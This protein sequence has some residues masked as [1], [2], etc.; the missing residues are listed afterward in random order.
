MILKPET[1]KSDKGLTLVELLV[2]IA[3]ISLIA[4]VSVHLFAGALDSW[5]RNRGKDE[6]LHTAMLTMERM[7]SKVRNTSWVLLPLKVSNPADP[8]YP[9]SSYYPRDI[10][11]VSGGIDNDGDGLIDED[12]GNDITGDGK[13]GIMGIDDDNNGLIDDKG[14]DDDDE[15][16]GNSEDPIDGIDNDGDGK[17][18]EDP[19]RDFLKAGNNDDGQGG[20]DEDPFDPLI[21]YLNG[22]T[23]MERQN[24]LT[25]TIS[26]NVIAENVTK[27]TVLLRRA[28]GN[29]LIDIY[30]KLDNGKDTVEL[31][32]TVLAHE[33][34]KR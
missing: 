24:V 21:Y 34:I 3:V 8:N 18:D 14:Q 7:V 19:N 20:D 17:F 23:L 6:L 4:G 2:S 5:N 11:A 31:S 1:L 15:A 25:A 29:T 28:N 22:T 12:P 9:A 13:S 16:G 26:D 33:M 30:L 27:F 10:L 32:T